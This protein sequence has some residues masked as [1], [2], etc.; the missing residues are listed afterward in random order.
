MLQHGNRYYIGNLEGGSVCVLGRG[1]TRE[2]IRDY[3]Q[4]KTDGGLE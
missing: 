1:G 2:M 3:N 4:Q